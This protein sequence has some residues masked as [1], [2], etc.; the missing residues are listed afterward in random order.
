VLNIR[1]DANKNYVPAFKY[2]ETGK[3]KSEQVS[4]CMPDA[5]SEKSENFIAPPEP[6]LDKSKS[7]QND[8]A[9]SWQRTEGKELPVP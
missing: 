8:I 2:N 3:K 6:H 5:I 4:S 9:A 1:Y 7:S